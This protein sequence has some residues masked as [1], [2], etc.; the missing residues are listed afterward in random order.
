MLLLVDILAL[1]LQNVVI[2]CFTIS[3]APQTGKLAWYS[4]ATPSPT[5]FI[6]LFWIPKLATRPKAVCAQLNKQAMLVLLLLFC[7]GFCCF[8]FVCW[9]DVLEASSAGN[10]LGPSASSTDLTREKNLIQIFYDFR[11]TLS[12][13]QH[14]VRMLAKF[15]F[16]L[17]E[18]MSS[19]INS[20]PVI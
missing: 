12:A 9:E 1:F 17:R 11:I 20:V 4:A 15:S 5:S 8:L 3:A 19:F 10:L 7:F 18:T 13:C 6:F 2:F 16:I 14:H